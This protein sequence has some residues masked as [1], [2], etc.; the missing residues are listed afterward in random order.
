MSFSS[1]SSL[2]M[3]KENFLADGVHHDPLPQEGEYIRLGSDYQLGFHAH[4]LTVF[5]GGGFGRA[6]SDDGVKT[7][8][9]LAPTYFFG[10]LSYKQ[11]FPH[12]Y[13]EPGFSAHYPFNEVL[14]T[15]DDVLVHEGDVR[16]L[17]KIKVGLEG[18]IFKAHVE[19]GYLYRSGGLSH[20]AISRVGAEVGGSLVS[21]GAEVIDKRTVVKDTIAFEDTD[22]FQDDRTRLITRVNAK[23]FYLYSINPTVT[24]VRGYLS[25][26]T[27]NLL[28]KLGYEQ[29]I[30]GS[31]AA[32]YREF[33]LS[34]T[35][36][37]S[38][39]GGM[40]TSKGFDVEKEP[41][42]ETLFN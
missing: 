41:Y 38:H 16:A 4:A 29:S 33:L 26:N 2:L 27:K 9:L 10:G 6:R 42:S 24:S 15:K 3:T 11:R 7:R 12:W 17:T 5:A 31:N 34:F 35:Y 23:S 25:L 32:K 36:D 13:V 28:I 20:L 14:H 18:K 21:L 37:L 40:K 1:E 19:S 8:E 30:L 39:L 22:S